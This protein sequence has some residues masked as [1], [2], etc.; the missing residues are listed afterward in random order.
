[1]YFIYLNKLNI[2]ILRHMYTYSC[3]Q[4]LRMDISRFMALYKCSSSSYYYY[5][6]R[7]GYT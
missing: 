3:T 6:A 2:I 7:A 5:L 4:R 1:M